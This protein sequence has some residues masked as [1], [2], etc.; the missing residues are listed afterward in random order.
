MHNYR[1]LNNVYDFPRKDSEKW[2]VR[3]SVFF[4]VGISLGLWMV[5]GMYLWAVW[6]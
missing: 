3:K 4:I 5:M 1:S 6:F 2:S